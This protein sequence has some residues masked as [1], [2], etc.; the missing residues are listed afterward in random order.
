L[1]RLLSRT[2]RQPSTC[3]EAYRVLECGCGKHLVPFFCEKRDCGNPKCNNVV[4]ARRADA[5][6]DRL[7]GGVVCYTVFTVPPELRERFLDPKVTANARRFLAKIL[8]QM[9]MLYGVEMSHPVGEDGITFHPH[10]NWL[11]RPR[12]GLRG[13]VDVDRL[14]AAWAKYLGVEVVDVYHRYSTED[15]KIKHWCRYVSRL[16]PGLHEWTG[17]VRWFGTYPKATT[18]GKVCPECGHHYRYLGKV[19]VEAVQEA[20]VARLTLGVDPP[21]EREGW[22][23]G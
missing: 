7:Q 12:P 22:K 11:W 4:H 3:R 10:Q 6:Y 1:G 18:S 2:T 23:G 5:A 19:S 20:A 14:R 9:G 15:G 16:F 17:Q 21:W 8:K 13:F